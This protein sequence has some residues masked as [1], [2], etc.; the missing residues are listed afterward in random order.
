[1]PR[2]IRSSLLE[3]RSARVKLEPRRRP[4]FT[5]ASNGIAIGYRRTATGAGS[6]SVRAA[7]GA[8]GNWLKAFGTA[9]DREDANGATVLTFWQA[10]DKAREL[11]RAGDDQ[12]SKPPSVDEALTSYEADLVA[13][14]GGA[15]NVSR[16][17]HNLPSTLAAKTVTLLTAAELR[18]WRNKL[19]KGGMA[20]A[21]ADRTARALSAALSLA[22]PVI[23]ATAWKTGLKRLPDSEEARQN[24]VLPDDVVRA[25]VSTSYTVD[26]AYGLLTEL[27]AVTGARRSQMLRCRVYDL[28]DTGAAPRIQLP[29]SRKG[30]SRK[31]VR[32]ALPISVELAKALRAAAVGR[33]ADAPLLLQADGSAWSSHTDRVF[34]KVTTAAGLDTALTPYCLRH[35]SIVRALLAGVPLQLVASSHDTSAAIIAKHYARYIVDTSEVVLRRAMLDLGSPAPAPNVVAIAARK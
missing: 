31:V 13:R 16:V 2:K 21:S 22:S 33:P 25:I 30:R 26:P 23:N 1:M 18:N 28:E 19:V 14:G 15:G 20:P 17:R 29:S 9:D 32:K 27:A 5:P 8:G 35:S 34:F 4:Y 11:A 7:D 3:T 24:A 12:G 10:V 6:W